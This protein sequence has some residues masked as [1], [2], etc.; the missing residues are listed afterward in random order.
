MTVC[1]SLT[2]TKS[3]HF[4]VMNPVLPNCRDEDRENVNKC[5]RD[6]IYFSFVDLF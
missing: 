3:G 5:S 6:V 2:L 1:L 4:S